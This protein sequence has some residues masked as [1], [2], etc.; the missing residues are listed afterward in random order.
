MG[1]SLPL[2]WSLLGLGFDLS[3]QILHSFIPRAHWLSLWSEGELD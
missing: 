1:E 3:S 2:G